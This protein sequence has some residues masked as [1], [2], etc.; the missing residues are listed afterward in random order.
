MDVT[1]GCTL[2]AVIRITRELPGS[3]RIYTY[4][5]EFVEFS[6]NGRERLDE[7]LSAICQRKAG[8]S[9]IVKPETNTTRL[10]ANPKPDADTR[11]A[12]T[13][14]ADRRWGPTIDDSP[15]AQLRG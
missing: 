7:I 4:G 10:A 11:P 12:T 3:P 9:R 8:D 14:L 13:R 6:E 1:S 5:A 15:D 2:K